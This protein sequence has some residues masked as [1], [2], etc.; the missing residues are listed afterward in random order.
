MYPIW[1]PRT[2]VAG[3]TPIAE[4]GWKVWNRT[5]GAVAAGDVVMFETGWVSA[6]EGAAN[7]KGLTLPAIANDLWDDPAGAWK[8]VIKP[9]TGKLRS[10]VF[11]RVDTAGADNEEIDVCVIGVRTI[12][13]IGKAS[14][15]YIRGHG[16]RATTSQLYGTFLDFETTAADAAAA[17]QAAELYASKIIALTR[18]TKTEAATP[19]AT[20]LSVMFCG[21]GF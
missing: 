19:A 16:V 6:A 20:S 14:T 7:S 21:F 18:E 5:G 8:H 11:A 4:M 3:S 2:P 13:I 17:V 12:N 10:G 9:S 15:A 1:F